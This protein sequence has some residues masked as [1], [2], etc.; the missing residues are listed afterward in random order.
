MYNVFMVTG[1]ISEIL[2]SE[3]TKEVLKGDYIILSSFQSNMTNAKND[4]PN[5]HPNTGVCEIPTFR[6]RN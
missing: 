5:P 3:K 4:F 2:N 6:S 1:G